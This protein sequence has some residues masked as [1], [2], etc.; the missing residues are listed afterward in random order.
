M[1]ACGRMM[2]KR[3]DFFFSIFLLKKYSRAA[4][5][6]SQ[7]AKVEAI[8]VKASYFRGLT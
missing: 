4:G 3:N 8:D 7:W 2:N 1:C 5:D 6:R